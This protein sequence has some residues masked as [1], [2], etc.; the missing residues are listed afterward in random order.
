M[1]DRL[2]LFQFPS[3]FPKLKQT[4]TTP[5]DIEVDEFQVKSEPG[6][7]VESPAVKKTPTAST[8]ES[9]GVEGCFGKLL[10]HASGKMSLSFGD[11]KM[12]VSS[13]SCRC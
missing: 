7:E 10:I 11:I 5:E 4:E 1:E 13:W 2:F 3:I 6:T 12:D 8:S 9:Q